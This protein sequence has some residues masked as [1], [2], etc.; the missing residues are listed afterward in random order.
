MRGE[1]TFRSPLIIG[2]RGGMT[3]E[4]QLDI[5]VPAHNRLGLLEKCLDILYVNTVSPFH[6]IVIDD[7][8]DLTPLW[9]ADF[10]RIHSNVTYIHSDVPYKSGNQIFNIGLEQARTDYVATVMNSMSVEPTWEIR[11][12]ELM[13]ENPRVGVVG[14]KCLFPNGLIESAGIRMFKYL[15]CDIGRDLPSHRLTSIY[16]VEAVQWA[17]ALL[18]KQA[19]AGNLD[20]DIFNG[21]KGVDDID[22]CFVV[23]SKGWELYFCGYGVGY[24]QP[25][26]TRGDASIN[27]KR[28]N[29]ENMEIFYKR[30]GLWELFQ[31]EYRGLTVEDLIHYMPSQEEAS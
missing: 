15:P 18:R 17:F 9:M 14:L 6:L 8:T 25:K 30:W 10:Q 20:E 28:L 23:K 7:S 16:E 22:N 1:A 2:R 26:A 31:K 27:G 19:V 24:H 4:Y 11:A 13:K 21:F 5:I 29:A 3:G 12:L